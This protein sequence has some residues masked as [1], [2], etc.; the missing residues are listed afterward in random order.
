[1][2]DATVTEL[3]QIPNPNMEIVNLVVSD[4]E[5]YTSRKFANIKG[6]VAT[7]NDDSDAALNVEF[8]GNVATVN[9]ASVTDGNL[10]LVLFGK[11]GN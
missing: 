8:S 1:M 3:V 10:T 11:L 5:T 9:W 2:A 4:G 6:A 7:S